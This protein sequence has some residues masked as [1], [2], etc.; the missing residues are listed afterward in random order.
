M[1]LREI[2]NAVDV[3]SGS[4]EDMHDRL[5]R[6]KEEYATLRQ[7][8]QQKARAQAAAQQQEGTHG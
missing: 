4:L 8:R 3:A 7:I 6:T 5:A 2:D 1:Q